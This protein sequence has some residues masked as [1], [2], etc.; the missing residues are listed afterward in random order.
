[1]ISVGRATRDDGLTRV[2]RLRFRMEVVE[3]LRLLKVR[4]TYSQLSQ[5]TGLPATVLSRYILGHVLPTFE[6]AMELWH[7]MTKK[8]INLRNEIMDRV[9]FDG[10]GFFDNTAVIYDP[11]IRKFMAVWI[12]EKLMGTRVDKILTAAVDGVPLAVTLSDRL[13]V[14]V[15][16][17]KKE[18]EVG[19]E[20]FWTTELAW[21]SGRR[22]TLYVPKQWLRKKD[23]VVIVDDVIRTGETQRALIELVKHVGAKLA[24]L[25]AL[26][27]I[28]DW[29]DKIDIPDG[30]MA[31]VL[32][33]LNEE[34]L[35][36][37]LDKRRGKG[38]KLKV[39]RR[40]SISA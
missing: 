21:P 17:A 11:F 31:E 9:K 39:A 10:N 30:C 15:V 4:Y 1:M 13:G 36:A 18:R 19:V 3:L 26:I 14:P 29:T 22:E 23:W 32:I 7:V 6:R 8:V 33:T 5:L 12:Y 28:G 20:E 27:S 38:E 35:N 40:N 2:E 34:I 37:S 16:I 25:F 24:G